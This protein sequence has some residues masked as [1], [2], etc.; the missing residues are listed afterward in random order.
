MLPAA[1]RGQG[2]F[3]AAP[4]ICATPPLGAPIPYVDVA[5]N[6]TAAFFAPNVL[7]TM[8]PT[9]TLGSF[10]PTS[11]GDN[12]GTMHWTFMGP[13]FVTMCFFPV[14]I[15]NLP[16]AT[17]CA[18]TSGNNFNAPRGAIV[19]P[20]LTNVFIGLAS[21]GASS[22]GAPILPAARRVVG[23]AEAPD[24]EHG[25]KGPA[26]EAVMI[27]PGVGHITLRIFSVATPMLVYRAVRALEGAG[28]RSLVLDL[29]GNPGGEIP[30]AL[31]LA[32]DF[33][34]PG[35][36]LV[37]QHDP[38]GDTTLHRAAGS[39]PHRFPLVI[40]IDRSTASAAEIFAACLGNC[41][42][43]VLVG[44]V[45]HGKGV[46]HRLSPSRDGEALLVASPSRFTLPSGEEIHGLGVT[47]DV[48]APCDQA[49]QVAA[50]AAE[51]MG[52]GTSV[53]SLRRRIAS[54]SATP[55]QSPPATGEPAMPQ[56]QPPVL[57]GSRPLEPLF[58]APPVLE[59]P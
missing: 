21:P 14:L 10:T 25:L 17:L 47:P 7:T 1:N 51:E 54:T 59:T 49:L 2:I 5:F 4:D 16:A 8:M 43:A 40:V 33:V 28:M 13:A 29:R 15:N 11:I 41:G 9:L 37:V 57:G 50:L 22:D 58:P 30:A 56:P 42:R 45:S 6:A 18:L 55:T 19:V 27:A 48:E 12:A 44:E 35:T 31:D 53:R 26:I 39:R 3:V 46:G 36:P 52:D 23:A 38:D 34:E 24:L 20:S 32:G